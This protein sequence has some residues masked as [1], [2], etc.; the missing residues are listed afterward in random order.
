MKKSEKKKQIEMLKKL[1]CDNGEL[2]SGN[3]SGVRKHN[4][5]SISRCPRPGCHGSGVSHCSVCKENG[6]YVCG[7][8]S[9]GHHVFDGSERTSTAIKGDVKH[10]RFKWKELEECG[11]HM[12]ER[13]YNLNDTKIRKRGYFDATLTKVEEE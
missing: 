7:T 8:N 13:V 3:R 4:H 9:K 5:R 1:F 6:I 12:H 2:I 10:S 11:A